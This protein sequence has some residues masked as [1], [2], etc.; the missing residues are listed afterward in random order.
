MTLLTVNLSNLSS[1]AA[2]VGLGYCG[3][4]I[5]SLPGSLI[6]GFNYGYAIF[7]SR[8]Y[9]AKNFE[10]YKLYFLQGLINL[11]ILILGLITLCY[12]SYEVTKWIGQ[13]EEVALNAQMFA[14]NLLPAYICFFVSH[15]VKMTLQAQEK[16]QPLVYVDGTSIVFHIVSSYVLGHYIQ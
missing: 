14:R 2:K 5:R 3:V 9:G 12:C 6:F 8:T 4:L 11:S 10:K 16:T 7:A 13:T 15:F 1:P